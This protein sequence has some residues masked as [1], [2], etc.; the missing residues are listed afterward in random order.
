MGSLT[1]NL[2]VTACPHFR[3]KLLKKPDVL[4]PESFRPAFHKSIEK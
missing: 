3:E 2:F 4:I 1:F